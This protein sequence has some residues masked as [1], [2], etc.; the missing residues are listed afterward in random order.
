MKRKFIAMACV[1][2]MTLALAACGSSGNKETDTASSK[3][4]S[5][6]SVMSE[7]SDET[8]NEQVTKDALICSI[9]KDGT[10]IEMHADAEGDKITTLTEITTVDTSQ[11]TDEEKQQMDTI[12]SKAKEDTASVDGVEYSIDEKDGIY[13][14]TVKMDLKNHLKDIT[15][16]D[17]LQLVA[18][19][20]GDEVEY[21]SLSSARESLKEDGWTVE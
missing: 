8:S 14:E 2:S 6:T 18:V 20:D 9:E 15:D 1:C 17:V 19:S 5:E 13:T 7:S 12:V 3:A 10:K 4:G 11:Y 21:L 16:A